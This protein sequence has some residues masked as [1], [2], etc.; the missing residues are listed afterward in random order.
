MEFTGE[1]YVPGIAGLEELFIEH[2]SRYAFA[3]SLASG[4]RVLDVGSG[5]GYGTHH[6]AWRGAALAVGVDRSPEAVDFARAKYARA[7]LH[8]ALMD[9][10]KLAFKCKFGLVTCFELIE[11]V[12][13]AE[14]VLRGVSDILDESGIFVV[15]TPNKATY[16][17]GGEGGR[18]PFHVR[19]Y[20]RDEFEA[21]LKSAFPAVAVLGQ[22]WVEGM[23]LDSHP[24]LEGRSPV[25][26]T[27]L[28]GALDRTPARPKEEGH[29]SGTSPGGPPYFVGVCTRAGSL[30]R[31]LRDILPLGF[32]G[33]AVR[34][35]SLK[36]AARQLQREF[37]K[38]GRW[39]RSLDREIKARDETIVRLKR[40]AAELRIRF[41]ESGR[42][43][44]RLNDELRRSGALVERLA[45]ENRNLREK[46]VPAGSSRTPR[47][48][49]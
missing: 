28:D 16:T 38:R 21:L 14:A 40:E 35:D 37:D 30:D 43:A 4:R 36:E 49:K 42:W 31:A 18:N 24:G 19:E 17:A 41:E 5:C 32:Y 1:R 15:S 44:R 34:H 33:T 48:T 3:G 7:G 25:R 6:L 20:Y 10:T 11:H 26:A 29:E 23:V 27:R 13:D 12:R 2:M 47:V 45:R 46:L 22:T 8:F 39:A 9:A